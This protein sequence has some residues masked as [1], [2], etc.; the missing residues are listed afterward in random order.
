MVTELGIFQFSSY[1]SIVEWH[2]GSFKMR[3]Y[4]AAYTYVQLRY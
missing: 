4:F 2:D 3:K 1:N